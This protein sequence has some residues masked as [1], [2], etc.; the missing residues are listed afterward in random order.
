M[1]EENKHIAM[2]H[3]L[4]MFSGTSHA[5]W[6]CPT[7]QSAVGTVFPLG[8][9]FFIIASSLAAQDLEPTTPSWYLATAVPIMH[10]LCSRTIRRQ[11]DAHLWL[12]LGFDS[13]PHF[14]SVVRHSSAHCDIRTKRGEHRIHRTHPI[15]SP[16]SILSTGV[17]FPFLCWFLTWFKRPTL[18][19]HTIIT[20]YLIFNIG[21]HS[22]SPH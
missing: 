18:I 15:S 11:F 10:H 5:N 22:S 9:Y 21:S 13:Y 6:L 4:S 8:L 1:H 14:T 17:S 20:L 12:A 2:H 16:M 7:L 3:M 19:S